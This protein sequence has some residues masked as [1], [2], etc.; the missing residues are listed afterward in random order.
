MDKEIS[1]LISF[2][3]IYLTK[4]ELKLLRYISKRVL[5]QAEGNSCAATLIDHG[6]ARR[7]MTATWGENYMFSLI[8]ENRGINYLKYIRGKDSARRTETARF[9]W[10]T[11]IAVLALLIAIAA[12]AIDIWQLGQ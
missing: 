8:I 5:L 9:V 4:E 2:D 11:V 1:G 7:T 6:F 10:T 12:L 3:Q